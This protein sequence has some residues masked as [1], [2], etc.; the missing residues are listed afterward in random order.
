MMKLL[1][2]MNLTPMWVPFLLAHGFE[3]IHWSSVGA[4]D[5]PDE[6]IFQFAGKGRF[7][8]LTQDLDFSALLGLTKASGPS[9][10]QLRS[11]DVAPDAIGGR[12]LSALKQHQQELANGAIVSIDP[13]RARVRV[14]PLAH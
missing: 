3:V 11:G 6:E 2:D 5:A 1:L 8:V 9:V 7:V 10:I 4:P 12:M 14:L 13:F